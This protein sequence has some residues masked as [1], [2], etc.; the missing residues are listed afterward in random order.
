MQRIVVANVY[1]MYPLL[2]IPALFQWLLFVSLNSKNSCVFFMGR[3]IN[4]NTSEF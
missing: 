3:T 2:K 1:F 4:G